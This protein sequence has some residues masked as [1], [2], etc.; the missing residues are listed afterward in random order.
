M[1]AQRMTSDDV[2]EYAER[3]DQLREAA[4]RER[5]TRRHAFWSRAREVVLSMPAAIGVRIGG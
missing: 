1:T 3:I 5:R 4:R 2:R